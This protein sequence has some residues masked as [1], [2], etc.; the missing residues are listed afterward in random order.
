MKLSNIAKAAAS[1]LLELPCPGCDQATPEND[2]SLCADCLAELSAIPE[3]ICPGCGGAVDGALNECSDCLEA[4]S[5][6]WD[7]A[8]SLYLYS[9]TSR[10]LILRFKFRRRP[11]LAWLFAP[12][13]EELL[14]EFPCRFDAIVPIPLSRERRFMRGYNQC[15]LLAEILSD[16][17][18]IPVVNALKRRGRSGHQSLRGRKERLAAMKRAFVPRKGVELEGKKVLLLDDVFT[19]G[20]TLTAAG[21]AIQWLHPTYV[22]VVTIA[23]R[24]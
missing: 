12:R 11:E 2:N 14:S 20:A 15:A 13:L 22:G 19:T 5:R 24:L 4:G 3:P 9:G 23:R 18:G 8:R 17:T 7:L 16:A 10:E 21:M 6:P 1:A